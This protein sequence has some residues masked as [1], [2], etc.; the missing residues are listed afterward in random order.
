MELFFILTFIFLKHCIA[1][2]KEDMP[3]RKLHTQND[4]ESYLQ[5]YIWKSSVA[6]VFIA[7][8][9][10]LIAMKTKTYEHKEN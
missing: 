1:I 9:I 7:R 5:T 3:T 4:I 10:A 8:F 2:F 6:E